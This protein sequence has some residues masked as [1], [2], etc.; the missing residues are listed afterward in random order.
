MKLLLFSFLM[1]VSLILPGLPQRKSERII[2]AGTVLR[3][4]E[5]PSV[6]MD[7]VRM[8]KRKPR[9]EGE[10]H[11]GI[12]L[13]LH[14]NTRWDISFCCFEVTK[15]YGDIGIYYEVE[16]MPP[17]E[18]RLSSANEEKEKT[19][20][21]QETPDVPIGYPVGH[22]C[23]VFILPP[24]QSI[25]FSIPKEH[26]ADNLFIKIKFNYGWEDLTNVN[27]ILNPEHVVSFYGMNLPKK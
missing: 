12:W 13:K 6:Y 15:D 4:K 22:I 21:P 17:P 16:K 1:L 26:L 25:I 27:S 5:K 10:S 11:D 19:K 23:S 7:F 14:N 2:P 9:E 8:G 24:G 3:N 18:F 20:Q